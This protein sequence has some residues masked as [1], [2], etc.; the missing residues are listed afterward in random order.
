MM[1]HRILFVGE[2]V[3]LGHVSRPAVL[4]RWAREAG[5]EVH[6]AC[7]TRYADVARSEGLDPIAL[8][9]VEPRLFFSRLARGRFFYRI[10]E[11]QRY[12]RAE[13]ELIERIEPDLVVGDFRLTLPTS[14]RLAG[15]RCLALLNAH[16]SPAAP[17]ML[18][19][20][21][22]GVFGLIPGRAREA[23]FS[24]VEPL[25]FRYFAAPLD[26]LRRSL[27]L[28]TF[29][30]FREHY[31]SGDWC[32]YLDLP[33]LFAAGGGQLAVDDESRPVTCSLPPTAHSPLPSGH[34]FLGPVIWQ[35]R[36]LPEP[37][38]G[39]LGLERPLA[40]VS[41][42]SSGSAKH[43]PRIL[44][45]VLAAGFDVAAS[46]GD[47]AV[48]AELRSA[49]PALAGRAF[50]ARFFSPGRVL[51]RARVAICHGG[52]GTVYQA[53]AAGVPVLCRPENQDQHMVTRTVVAAGG[54]MAL[55]LPR[56]GQQLAE[57]AAGRCR[58]EAGRLSAAIRRHDTRRKWIGFLASVSA[59]KAPERPLATEERRI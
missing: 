14:A 3:A 32:A 45:A 59:A 34:F 44:A 16:L 18:S 46:G 36:G 17:R 53:L 26:A 30:D 15:V 37:D 38:L 56:V 28:E 50:M 29:K 35:P 1:R 31:S 48:W 55:E 19:A 54:G 22:G 25:A 2:A 43:L 27:G 58:L 41:T 8:E 52:S 13:L 23:L 40:Y 33:Q 20:P 49:L 21:E 10:E 47:E 11:L 9:T 4:A 24:A 5:C 51:E 57:L 6:F 12:V 42:G 39:D 7:G